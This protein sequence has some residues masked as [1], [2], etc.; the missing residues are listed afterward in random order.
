MCLKNPPSKIL[1]PNSLRGGKPKALTRLN[2]VPNGPM[3]LQSIRRHPPSA[4]RCTW[5]TYLATPTPT[6]LLVSG[7]CAESKCFIRWAGT[8]TDCQPSVEYRTSSASHATQTLPTTPTSLPHFVVTCQRNIALLQ[9]H[10][11]TSSRCVLNSRIKMK[12]SLKICS[13]A[14]AYLSTGRC[15]TQP[16][17]ITL[18]AQA[19]RRSCVT[20]RATRPTRKRHLHC[21]MLISA[22]RL[23]KPS[24]RTASV[25]ALFMT[26]HLQSPTAVATSSLQPLAQS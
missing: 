24:W 14:L 7:A 6:R 19:R 8:T 11:Q 25:P 1:K 3:Y 15:C 5:G 2:A 21:G 16:S 20:C 12:K 4:A 23:P 13:V 10:D 18:A 26:L 22:L 9:S 17:A